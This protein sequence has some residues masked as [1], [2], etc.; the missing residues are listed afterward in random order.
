M[1]MGKQH[2]IELKIDSIVLLEY[3]VDLEIESHQ[4]YLDKIIQEIKGNDNG[5]IACNRKKNQFNCFV[6]MLD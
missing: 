5:K 2:V 4:L 3:Q 1:I 6:G